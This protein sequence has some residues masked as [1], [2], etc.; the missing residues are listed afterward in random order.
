MS[1]AVQLDELRAAIADTDRAPYL[2][3]VSDEGRPH[4]VAVRHRWD[5]DLLVFAVGKRTLS[6][7]EARPHV[8]LLWPPLAA[9]GYSLIVD[10]DVAT[11][12]PAEGD[13]DH[14]VAL[15]ATRA[16]L[17]R[18]APGLSDDQYGADCVRLPT[19]A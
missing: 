8:T 2:V 6:N 1:I 12:T 5:G 11:T 7:A 15:R 16:T 14:T 3:T 9:D 17:H 4:T 19:T 13:G 18:P 10:A